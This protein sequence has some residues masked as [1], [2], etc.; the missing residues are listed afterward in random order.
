MEEVRGTPIGSD[1]PQESPVER[2]LQ[3][4]RNELTTY[5]Q[6]MLASGLTEEQINMVRAKAEERIRKEHE[7][8][9]GQDPFLLI[10]QGL[11]RAA[12]TEDERYLAENNTRSIEWTR[13][14]M[15]PF[16]QAAQGGRPV[17][18][19]NIGGAEREFWGQKGFHKVID[20]LYAW[21]RGEERSR[22]EVPRE[23]EERFLKE[24]GVLDREQ[25][26][27]DLLAS[28]FPEYNGAGTI[29]S[30]P[31]HE[32]TPVSDYNRNPDTWITRLP[33]NIEGVHARVN[34]SK[35]GRVAVSF[36]PEAARKV[37]PPP[38]KF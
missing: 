10:E 16:V 26:L 7:E 29:P 19:A 25:S 32:T 5:Q 34:T 9:Q 14:D 8:R 18:Y 17:S 6:D 37:Q 28:R 11:Q 20:V 3:K 22:V 4:A 2:A 1:A 33:T 13:R 23:F 27:Q 38:N 35:I 12:Q 30:G 21:E 24:L 36:S 15:S 31:L